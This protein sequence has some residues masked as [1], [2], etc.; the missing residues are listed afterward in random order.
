MPRMILV[1][2]ISAG[3]GVGL[4]VSSFA[5]RVYTRFHNSAP[6]PSI[7]PQEWQDR[8][9]VEFQTERT[10]P[11]W[12]AKAKAAV[13]V[14]LK[15]IG[16]TPLAKA[17]DC[18]SKSCVVDLEWPDLQ[19]ASQDLGALIAFNSPTLRCTSGLL[20]SPATATPYHAPLLLVDC[21]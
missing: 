19:H 21:I 11:K 15:Q 8:A 6:P 3:V 13:A 5:P 20:L 14:W 4:V 10:D 12:S 18:R 16:R 2:S 9:L 7:T 17:V 1:I